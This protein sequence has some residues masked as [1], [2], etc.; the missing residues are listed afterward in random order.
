MT[1][2]W[3]L[4]DQERETTREPIRPRYVLTCPGHNWG[5]WMRVVGGRVGDFRRF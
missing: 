2:S 4:S 3:A 5:G 1:L